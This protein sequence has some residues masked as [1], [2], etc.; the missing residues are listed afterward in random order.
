MGSYI[1]FHS[2]N[3]VYVDPKKPIRL[4]G[5]THKGIYIGDNVWIGAKATFLDGSQV[6]NN[7]IVAAGAIVASKF[8]DN[9]L[10]GGV[11]AKIIKTIYA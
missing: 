7:S 4:Q 5:V 11:P 1:S 8:P 3:H 2:E 10:I 6:G 9:V